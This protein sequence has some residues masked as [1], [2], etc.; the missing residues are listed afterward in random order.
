MYSRIVRPFSFFP[1]S[2]LAVKA[3]IE[4]NAI[5]EDAACMQLVS[6]TIVEILVL[7]HNSL[8]HFDVRYIRVLKDA[9][10]LVL[11]L[12][13]SRRTS[14]CVSISKKFIHE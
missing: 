13:H 3:L 2:L 11:Q 10:Y 4:L 14:C 1:Q 9:K 8:V 6:L 12:M 7:L 5:G